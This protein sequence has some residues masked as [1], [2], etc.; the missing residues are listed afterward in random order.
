MRA[1]FC[2]PLA[3]IVTG[4]I[5]SAQAPENELRR[6]IRLLREQIDRLELRLSEVEVHA[7]VAAV[8]PTLEPPAPEAIL[9]PEPPPPPQLPLDLS[10][11]LA[12]RWVKTGSSGPAASYQVHSASLFFGKTLGAWSFHSELDFDYG[13]ELE[14]GSIP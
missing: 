4:G 1:R 10:G 8:V 14:H 2:L 5:S 6:E 13:P 9:E 12:S 3:L 7:P 11:F